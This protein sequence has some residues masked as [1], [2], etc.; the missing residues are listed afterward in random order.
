[1]NDITIKNN[2]ESSDD[3]SRGAEKSWTFYLE[4]VDKPRWKGNPKGKFS[5]ITENLSK[6][7]RN[8]IL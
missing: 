2:K 4:Q 6:D 5:L 3:H 8:K 7:K 1:M